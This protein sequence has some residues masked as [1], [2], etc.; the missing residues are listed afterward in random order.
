MEYLEYSND[1]TKLKQEEQNMN[2]NLLLTLLE[3]KKATCLLPLINM[4]GDLDSLVKKGTVDFA[5]EI[6]KEIKDSQLKLSDIAHILE[7]S[8]ELLSDSSLIGYSKKI[9]EIRRYRRVKKNEGVFLERENV[10]SLIEHFI[11]L[12]EV[13]KKEVTQTESQVYLTRI[14]EA[15]SCSRNVVDSTQ[16]PP[17]I[18]VPKEPVQ[19]GL[20]NHID[21]TKKQ[22]ASTDD[23]IITPAYTKTPLE[24]IDHNDIPYFNSD[25]IMESP[26]DSLIVKEGISDYKNIIDIDVDF[27]INDLIDNW[28][29]AFNNGDAVHK[30]DTLLLAYATYYSN[31][32]LL[33]EK[34]VGD[35]AVW[36]HILPKLLLNNSNG[37]YSKK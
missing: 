2:E 16:K 1:N 29:E 37:Y 32:S 8:S 33:N 28:K 25:E 17:V 13:A 36:N 23:P 27:N 20:V 24:N 3:S 35:F 6:P 15:P 26:K 11:E 12:L 19:E 5:K 18:P 9:G 31:K 10:A 22:V 21:F 14:M 34:A 7:D 4:V 30:K